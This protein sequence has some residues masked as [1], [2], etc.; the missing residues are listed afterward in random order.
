MN[1]SRCP[2]CGS[3]VLC[4]PED[5]GDVTIWTCYGTD[6]TVEMDRGRQCRETEA[7]LL[8]RRVT[9]WKRQCHI[10][11]EKLKPDNILWE[12]VTA[13]EPSLPK[14]DDD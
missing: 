10:F 5:A 13:A 12:H 3:S 14:G 11:F 2:Y 7:A 6:C 8:R 1:E 9:Y 4:P